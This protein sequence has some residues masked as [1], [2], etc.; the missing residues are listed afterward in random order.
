MPRGMVISLATMLFACG[1]AGAAQSG[2]WIDVPF[3]SQQKNGCGAAAISMIMQYWERQQGSP[4]ASS[5]DS[6]QIFRVL[7]SKTA[8]GIYASSMVRYFQHNGYRVFA[9]AGGWPDFEHNLAK[10][11][12]LI[13]ALKPAAGASLHYVVVAGLD[14][15]HRSVLVNDPAER[16]LLK[17]DDSV[18][19]REWKA[20]GYWTLLAVPE[21]TAH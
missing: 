15:Q 17:E 14:P 10:G 18:F 6:R 9:F 13:A 8:H 1:S 20:A 7:E 4:A 2:S 16:K 12:P 11:R 19:E 3:V 5:A 21:V